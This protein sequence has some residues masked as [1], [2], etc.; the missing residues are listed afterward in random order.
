MRTI[1][2]RT[3]NKRILRRECDSDTG[4]LMYFFTNENGM[5]RRRR[6]E[7]LRNLSERGSDVA[8]LEPGESI[9]VPSYLET[10]HQSAMRTG[11]F[12]ADR[13]FRRYS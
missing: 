3:K 11:E 9:R 2:N 7:V 4:E 1:K 10:Y 6:G 5:G 12:R 8:V 13:Q